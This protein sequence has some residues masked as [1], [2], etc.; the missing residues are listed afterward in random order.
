MGIKPQTDSTKNSIKGSAANNEDVFTFKPK[1]GDKSAKIA[2][3]L[4]TDF[5]SRQQQHLDKQKKN[6]SR[7]CGHMALNSY[8]V[9]DPVKM[10]RNRE[11]YQSKNSMAAMRSV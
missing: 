4:G 3:S 7:S 8:R 5:M 11:V 2:E 6:V 9:W 10:V 1:L